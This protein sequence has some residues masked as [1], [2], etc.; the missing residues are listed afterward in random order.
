M[1]FCCKRAYNRCLTR[2]WG[3]AG[4]RVESLPGKVT[5]GVQRRSDSTAARSTEMNGT[6]WEFPVLSSKNRKQRPRL[7]LDDDRDSASLDDLPTEEDSS[8]YFMENDTSVSR[9]RILTDWFPADFVAT[10]SAAQ[11]NTDLVVSS[12]TTSDSVREESGLYSQVDES[13][14]TEIDLED[15][16]LCSEVDEYRA[17]DTAI[18]PEDASDFQEVEF[19]AL[20]RISQYLGRISQYPHSYAQAVANTATEFE[21]LDSDVSDT[22]SVWSSFSLS[23]DQSTTQPKL[24]AVQEDDAYSCFDDY[25][26]QK[27]FGTRGFSNKRRGSPQRHASRAR[28]LEWKAFHM[29]RHGAL[30]QPSTQIS[31]TAD[32]STQLKALSK[33][34]RKTAPSENQ[35]RGLSKSLNKTQWSSSFSSARTSRAARQR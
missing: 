29:T 11:R 18:Q 31:D 10:H 12:C 13:V 14:D 19:P 3:A 35:R 8:E 28:R 33:R 1:A 22:M 17:G 4:S 23:C 20:G 21:I 15:W 26:A 5:K 16:C 2:V 9:S 24:A 32:C 30:S 34:F 27:S 7:V 6:T 25:E